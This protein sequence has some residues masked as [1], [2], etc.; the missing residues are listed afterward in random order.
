MKYAK[1]QMW[2]TIIPSIAVDALFN[3]LFSGDDDEMLWAKIGGS[4]MKTLFGGIVFVRDVANLVAS[5][6]K[7]DYQLTPAG[8]PIKEAG[9]LAK[10]IGQG[11]IDTPL[12]KSLIMTAGYMGQIPGARQASRAYSVVA[13]ED[14]PFEI[15]EFESWYRVLVTGP[16]RED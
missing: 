7:F 11:E 16:K 1:N 12:I 15:D 14:T 5:G 8:N 6:F 13:D 3:Q 10:Q 2:I 9:N 4:I